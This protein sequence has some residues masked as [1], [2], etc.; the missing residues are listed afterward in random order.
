MSRV[1]TRT[2]D[3]GTTGQLFGGRVAKGGELVE[4][5][6]DI[7]EAVSALG[8]ARAD[9]A[10][11][12]I[13]QILLGVQRELFILAADLSVNPSHR[14]RLKPGISLTEPSMVTGLERLIDELTE[15]H[16]L[17]PVF[18]VPG[19]TR[20]EA[21]LDFART[22]VRR[23][24]RHMLR[25]KDAG[26]VV[27]EQAQQYLNRLSDLVFVLARQAADGAEEPVSHA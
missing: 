20:L 8:V 3:D 6:G 14:D 10:D 11:E 23:A 22:V 15:Q 13:A 12:S 5:L 24:E 21:A 19:T 1:Y 18:L 17:R 16:P 9:C 7:D 4:A 26:H 27:S 25:A 2:G